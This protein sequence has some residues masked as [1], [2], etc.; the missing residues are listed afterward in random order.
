MDLLKLKSLP[1]DLRNAVMHYDLSKGETLFRQGEPAS[2]F[3][4]VETGRI[5]LVRYTSDDKVVT[6]QVAE[7]GNS[8]GEI[9]LFSQTYPCSAVAEVASR[10]IAYPKELILSAIRANPELAEDFIAMLVQKIQDLKLRIE[11]RDIRAAHK[12]LLRY[13]RYL[14]ASEEQSI[15]S[16][17]RP[18]KEI[19]ADLGL[20]PETLSRALARLE[21]E[22]KIARTRL[23]ITL[24]QSSAA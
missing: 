2:F 9:A 3:F 6:F 19:A 18:L 12:R 17:D 10:A 5:Q 13:L 1:E 23:Q 14:A 8:L 4:T 16:F 24:Q 22:G 11:L 15:V 20:T 7:P 21:R